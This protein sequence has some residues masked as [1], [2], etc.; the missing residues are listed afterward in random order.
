MNLS[1]TLTPSDRE[2]LEDCKRALHCAIQHANS[3]SSAL[4]VQESVYQNCWTGLRIKLVSGLRHSLQLI[5][6]TLGSISS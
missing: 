4:M 5:D 1:E 2:H 3:I 6:T